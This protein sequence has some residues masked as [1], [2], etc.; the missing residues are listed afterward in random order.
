MGTIRIIEDLFWEMLTNVMDSNPHPTSNPAQSL[1]NAEKVT[2]LFIYIFAY[3][4]NLF[5]DFYFW[6]LILKIHRIL[7]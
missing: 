5:L 4:F 3:F 7:D 6:S 2:N 1:R